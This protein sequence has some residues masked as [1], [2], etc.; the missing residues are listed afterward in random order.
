MAE[1]PESKQLWE[2]APKPGRPRKFQNE[3]ELWEHFLAYVKFI[4]DNPWF[5]LENKVVDKAIEEVY[6]PRR[7]PYSIGGLCVFLGV[8]ESYFREFM[9]GHK[10]G[11][12]EFS[13]VIEKI[14]KTIET[15]QLQGASAGFFNANIISRVLGL[16]DKQEVTQKTITVK[17]E[18]EDDDT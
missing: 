14:K 13:P 18:D 10:S 8:G 1:K 12:D 7:I 5:Q 2:V 11:G 9:N 6:T 17:Q 4:D 16:A 3:D 15:Q